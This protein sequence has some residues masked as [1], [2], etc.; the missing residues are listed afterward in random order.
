MRG[1]TIRR[2]AAIAAFVLTAVLSAKPVLLRFPLTDRHRLAVALDS[3]SEPRGYYPEYPAF[4]K[5]VRAQTQTGDRIALVVPS[6]RR[7]DDYTHAYLRASYL[8]AGR[9]VLPVVPLPNVEVASPLPTPQ[10]VAVWGVG[11]TAG[12]TGTTIFERHGGRLVKVP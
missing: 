9:Q 2:G 4:L 1:M 7:G 6:G 12:V 11:T 10:F 3:F 8:L 5:D